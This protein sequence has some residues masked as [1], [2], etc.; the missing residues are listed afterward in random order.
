MQR[1]RK[2][3]KGIALK[4]IRI[5]GWIWLC[6]IGL[7]LLAT[8]LIQLPVVQ[9]IITQKT[10]EFVEGKIGTRVSLDR[11]SLSFP[12]RIVLDGLYVEDQTR[13]TLLYAGTISV[14][15]DLIGLLSQRIQLNDVALENVTAHVNRTAEGVFN[16]DY[17]VDSFSGEETPQETAEPGW[18][19]SIYGVTL[20]TI[21]ARYEDKLEGNDIAVVL[22]ELRVRADEF[23]FTDRIINLAEVTL[24]DVR[25]TATQ[26]MQTAQGNAGEEPSYAAHSSDSAGG[27]FISVQALELNRILVHYSH[28]VAGTEIDLD[29]GHLRAE[30][31]EIDLA[32]RRFAG[33]TFLLANTFLA[34]HQLQSGDTVKHTTPASEEE[35]N[36]PDWQ[37]ALDRLT[38]NG[39]AFQYYDFNSQRISGFDPDHMWFTNFEMDIAD[40]NLGGGRYRAS[41]NDLAFQEHSG[42]VLKSMTSE[43]RIAPTQAVVENLDV[44]TA[45]SHLRFDLQSEFPSLTTL[46]ENLERIS[47]DATIVE[48]HVGMAD[49]RLLAAALLSGTPVELPADGRIDL[50]V[51]AT[52]TVADMTIGNLSLKMLDQTVL[53]AKG[54]IR[55]ASTPDSLRFRIMLEN[56]HTSFADMK[57]VLPDTVFPESLTVPEWVTL[58]GEFSGTTAK[59]DV[60]ANLDSDLGSVYVDAHLDRDPASLQQGYAG[61]VKVSQFDLGKFLKQEDMGVLDLEGTLEGNGMS[62][63]D[64][65]VYARVNVHEFEFR[66]YVYRDLFVDGD[67]DST[68]FSGKATMRDPNLSF[69]LDGDLDYDYTS[70]KKQYHFN[71]DLQLAD[72]QALNLLQRPM[73]MQFKLSVDLDDADPR[74]LNGKLSIHDAAINNGEKIYKVDSL[75]VASINQEGNS[76]LTIDS[77]LIQGEFKGTFDLLSMPAVLEQH[78]STYY[79][80]DI[81]PATVPTDAQQFDFSL[82]LRNTS[83]LTEVLVP[84][85]EKIDPGEITGSFDS[86]E[87]QLDLSIVIHE[88]KHTSIEATDISLTVESDRRQL[89][90]EFSAGN[91]AAGAVS[92]PAAIFSGTVAGDSIETGIV[93]YDSAKEE[94]YVLRGIFR[95]LEDAYRFSLL[96]DNVIL[97]YDSWSV[98]RENAVVVG[99]NGFT[100]EHLDLKFQDQEIRFRA[101]F[102]ADS[103]L[104]ITL[105]QLQLK[106]LLNIAFSDTLI[107]G[108]LQGDINIHNNETR[109][110][111]EAGIDIRS[112]A[113]RDKALGDMRIEVNQDQPGQTTVGVSAD[114]AGIDMD[115]D[116]TYDAPPGSPPAVQV[117][118]DVRALN[119]EAIQPFVMSQATGLKGNLKSQLTIRGELEVPDING[120]LT[121]EDTEVVPAYTKSPLK[122]NNETIAFSGST[123][124]LNDFKIRDRENN[125]LVLVGSV[126]ANRLREYT[127]DLTATARN[128]HL[129]NTRA[130]D[131]D[132][133]YGQLWVNILAKIK[134]TLEHPQVEMNMSLGEAS[135]FTYVV[136][137]EQAGVMESKDIVV[138]VDKDKSSDSL[139]NFMPMD[140]VGTLA[141]FQGVTLT[142]RIELKDE[143][144]FTIVLDPMT[145]DK[146]VVNGNSTLTLDID[147]T[148]NMNLS[149]RY[150]LTKGTYDFTFYKLAK[151]NFVIE[152]GSSITWSGEP[153]NAELNITARHRV[154]ASPIDLFPEGDQ[155]DQSR[156][157]LPFLVFLH[158]RGELLRPEIS[159]SLDMPEQQRGA[160]AG[161]VYAKIQDINTRE[162]DLN[163]QVFALL[164]LRRFVADNPFETQSGGTLEAAARTSVNRMLTDQLNRMAQNIKGVELT[165]D[166][167]SYEQYDNGRPSDR[168]Q[169]QLGVSK[170]LLNDRL[171]VKL[172][173]N[174]D[175][176]GSQGQQGSFSDYIGDLAL[177]YKLTEDGRF[178]INGFYNSDYDMID[179]ELKEAGVGL[180]Y[181]K[182]YDSLKELF[183]SNDR[184]HE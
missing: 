174:V 84:D 18:Y 154:E 139:T 153:L 56:L 66:D 110:P 137:Q 101:P 27:F 125:T 91:I 64:I 32:G 119:L 57:A 117:E 39:N 15:A 132:M 59:P 134:G 36:S 148:G 41:I 131:N 108:T 130:G 142:S 34:Y 68:I 22:G 98:P 115:I 33:G 28:T 86:E 2:K 60:K 133:F 63:E 61:T 114:G 109:G 163:K 53:Q 171:V 73:K 31:H 161:G 51:N 72:L 159:F 106:S 121:F 7:L 82:D 8:L 151:R 164:I 150:E 124:T 155:T 173:G 58:S 6:L 79:E 184:N 135:D 30:D 4:T 37:V 47:F 16:F 170:R 169:L 122:L 156:Q 77:D 152:S 116:G 5:A 158:V 94:Q 29:L 75:L 172:S 160:M 24:G 180:I 11:I 183:K 9:N 90:Y 78:F 20:N 67:L 144:T 129:L 118:V 49:I 44:Q 55:N 45:A 87:K 80:L 65:D 182:D 145:E 126:T 103:A 105:E 76:S 140:S 176:E 25:S 167:Q 107:S 1:N 112:L 138:F 96:P 40:I 92:I 85:L 149:G 54:N 10:I 99:K 14:D 12:K 38:L 179:G 111:L 165:F 35:G 100:A 120:S 175:L 143:E 168:T 46:A 88:L 136:P 177:E 50:D 42:L 13:D 162:S 123:V 147:E 178:R 81:D 74:N 95:S 181:I 62:A 128:F 141:P 166:L 113:V 48:S 19:F 70:E 26:Y 71:L 93:V 157:R 21:N 127:M 104:N 97:N 69:E 3:I 43:V 102:G 89:D 17:I 23:D 83:L 146:L 52:G